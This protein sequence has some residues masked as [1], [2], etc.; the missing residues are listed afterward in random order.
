MKILKNK[1]YKYVGVAVLMLS[2]IAT[3]CGTCGGNKNGN[4]GTVPNL[5]PITEEMITAAQADDTPFLADMLRKLKDNPKGVDINDK[6]PNGI[7]GNPLSGSTAL[8]RATRLGN[9][10]IVRALLDRGA[11]VNAADNS[12]N[13]PLNQAISTSNFNMEVVCVLL[14]HK[15]IDVNKKGDWD[16]TPLYLAAEWGRVEVV[17]ELLARPG[18]DVNVRDKDGITPLGRVGGTPQQKAEIEKLLRDKGATT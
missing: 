12:K 10:D 11:D 3:S 5:T 8:L 4:R 1:N 15:D 13:T 14:A 6:D 18:I 17:K 7:N 2:V 9:V 16:Q